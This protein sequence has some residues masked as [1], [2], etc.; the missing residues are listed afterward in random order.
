V[1]LGRHTIPDSVSENL[2]SPNAAVYHEKSNEAAVGVRLEAE[3]ELRPRAR[4]VVAE[5]GVGVSLG[6]ELVTE[7]VVVKLQQLR[8]FREEAILQSRSFCGEL[9]EHI[10]A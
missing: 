9:V 3:H 10:P 7:V 5:S 4:R 6:T 2:K 8:H 1:K